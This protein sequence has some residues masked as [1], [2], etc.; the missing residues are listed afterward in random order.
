LFLLAHCF[1]FFF[2]EK[3]QH[4]KKSNSFF[5]YLIKGPI[6]GRALQGTNIFPIRN[7][8]PD[9]YLISQTI[10]LTLVFP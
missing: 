3:N 4:S 1:L 2:F 6:L 10:I 9:P 5:A 8:L 7:R